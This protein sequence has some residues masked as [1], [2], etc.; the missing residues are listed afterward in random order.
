M[1]MKSPCHPM[2]LRV[3][4]IL[5]VLGGLAGIWAGVM[6][7][8]QPERLRDIRMIIPVCAY[9]VATGIGTALLRKIPAVLLAA[10]LLIAGI[11]TVAGVLLDGD[12]KAFLGN[13]VLTLPML[14]APA[15]VVY[16]YWKCFRG[17]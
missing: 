15:F 3:L 16:R 12:V 10:P 5:G 7:A 8:L 17:L 2:P 11:W 4:G 9:F 6:N 14:A 13:L 1:K